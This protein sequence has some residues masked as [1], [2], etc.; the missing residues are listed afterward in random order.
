M[1][2]EK[3]AVVSAS[4]PPTW[5]AFLRVVIGLIVCTALALIWTGTQATI[6]SASDASAIQIT[7]VYAEGI[8]HA[9]VTIGLG[10]MGYV[11]TRA[12]Q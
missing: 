11:V 3:P 10:I 8:F 4:R 12:G 9:V 1:T 6:K 5:A 2:T 7:Q